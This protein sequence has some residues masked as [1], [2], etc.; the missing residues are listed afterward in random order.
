ME[1]ITIVL[2]NYPH[3]ELIKAQHAIAGIEAEFPEISP[4]HDAFDDMVRTQRYDVCEM[5]IGAFL[6]AHD[7]GKPLLLLPAVMVGGFH[8]GSIFASPVNT[9]PSPAA[10]RGE[11]IGVRA[12]SQTTGLDENHGNSP[13]SITEIPHPLRAPACPPARQIEAGPSRIG[14]VTHQ[15]TEGVLL[16][17]YSRRRRGSTSTQKKGLV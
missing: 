3:T 6:Q 8:H 2:G 17:A 12:Y 15:S 4:V 7:A 14:V 11:R 10:V 13:G 16:H 5:A 9:P 1:K